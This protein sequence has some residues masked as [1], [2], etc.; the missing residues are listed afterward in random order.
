MKIV[1]WLK[2]KIKKIKNKKKIKKK[3]KA[4]VARLFGRPP[5][6]PPR[7]TDCQSTLRNGKSVY[8][9]HCSGYKPQSLSQQ[10]SMAF[11]PFFLLL[12][13]FF[14]FSLPYIV[15][16]MHHSFRRHQPQL[17]LPPTTEY[18]QLNPFRPETAD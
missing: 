16:F 17:T 10:C 7:P 8:E 3:T 2:K 9:I 18:M 4:N 11:F 14:Y 15:V 12:F 1:H 5:P 13:L 6:P